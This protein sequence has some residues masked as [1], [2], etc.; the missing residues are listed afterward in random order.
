MSR[1]P[2]K[3]LTISPFGKG[4]IRGIL[5]IVGVV[6]IIDLFYHVTICSLRY[7]I[8]CEFDL[9]QCFQLPVMKTYYPEFIFPKKGN[10]HVATNQDLLV[11]FLEAGYRPGVDD[12][13]LAAES[14][15]ADGS[16]ET[17]SDSGGAR[18][19]RDGQSQSRPL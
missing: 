18:P 4:G 16:L 8:S 5:R 10:L 17:P 7:A 14:P 2:K 19:A 15:A 9:G 1:R 6:L 3:G 13:I 11:R 12:G